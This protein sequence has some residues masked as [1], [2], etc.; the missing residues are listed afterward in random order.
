MRNAIRWIAIL[1][2]QATVS[3]EA[4][5]QSDFDQAKRS[6]DQGQWMPISDFQPVAGL[7]TEKAVARSPGVDWSGGST[8]APRVDI[9]PIAQGFGAART[10]TD[11]VKAQTSDPE[12]VTLAAIKA[13]HD[14]VRALETRIAAQDARIAILERTLESYTARN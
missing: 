4:A 1:L 8:D 2:L 13:L 10:A 12:N 6:A 9:G 3:F 11:S 14:E 5:A 7:D